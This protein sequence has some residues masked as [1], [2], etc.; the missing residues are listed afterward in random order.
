MLPTE[1]VSGNE[2]TPSKIATAVTTYKA[3]MGT[4]HDPEVAQQIAN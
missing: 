4:S 1:S 3:I 2:W